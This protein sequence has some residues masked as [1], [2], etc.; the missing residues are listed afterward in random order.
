MFCFDN[1]GSICNFAMATNCPPLL[2]DVFH[3]IPCELQRIIR[4]LVIC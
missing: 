1:L 4:M 2:V 3:P